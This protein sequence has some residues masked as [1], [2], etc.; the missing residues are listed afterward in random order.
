MSSADRVSFISSTF[1]ICMPFISFSC[2]V[3]L[4][5]TSRTL[6]NKSGEGGHL[7]LVPS[8]KGKSVISLAVQ[9]FRLHASTAEGMG[10]IPGGG[11]KIPHATWRGQK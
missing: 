5:S 1:P 2:L 4:A 6:L 7:C 10:S 8:L 11:N 9:W 3:V